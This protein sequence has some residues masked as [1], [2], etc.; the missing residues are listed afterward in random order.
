M[1]APSQPRSSAPRAIGSRPRAS[2]HGNMPPRPIGAG[3]TPARR[4]PRRPT[5]RRAPPPTPRRRR[6]P[7]RGHNRRC[8]GLSPRALGA[9]G[10]RPIRAVSTFDRPGQSVTPAFPILALCRSIP[11]PSFTNP[12]IENPRCQAPMARPRARET[13]PKYSKETE[14]TLLGITCSPPTKVLGRISNLL[15]LN[16]ICAGGAL[17]VSPGASAV[18]LR[19]RG[20]GDSA[21]RYPPRLIPA[22]LPAP[23]SPFAAGRLL[24]VWG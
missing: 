6:L 18:F 14:W 9:T 2:A 7:R 22:L 20:V 19:P 3:S 12:Q 17:G 5:R 16:R 10:L 15:S 24:A 13:A 4:R 11:G 21:L 23:F 8:P 1:Q